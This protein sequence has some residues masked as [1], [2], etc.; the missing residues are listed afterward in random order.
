MKVAFCKGRF[1]I[2]ME[3]QDEDKPYIEL[4][5][6]KWMLRKLQ[7]EC[8]LALQSIQQFQNDYTLTRFPYNAPASP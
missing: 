5:A 4:L 8:V 7:R 3:P 1:E 6:E 2:I